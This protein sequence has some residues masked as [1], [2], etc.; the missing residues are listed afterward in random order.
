[1]PAVYIR[2]D[3]PLPERQEYDFYPTDRGTVEDALHAIYRG[4]FVPRRILDPGAGAGIWGEVARE[5]WRNAH[6]TGVELRDVPSHP[7]YDEWATGSFL[8]SGLELSS[9]F[10]LVMGN[11]PYGVAEEFVRRS[12]SLLVPGGR[13]V[14]LLKLSFMA[15]KHRAANLYA[16]HPPRWYAPCG[17][18]PSFTGDGKSAPE[19]Y[20][21]CIWQRGYSGPQEVL[22]IL[23]GEAA[24]TWKRGKRG[25]RRAYANN[26]D[27]QAA[28]RRRQK[29]TT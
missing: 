29:A 6:I 16:E 15:G 12:L 14:F 2:T 4:V 26:A 24:A 28:Y 5:R 1:M 3:E 22:R 13:L 8:D 11:P 7:A 17:R 9:A 10:D 27:K 18:R 23:P 19:E 25:F 21:L 20:T